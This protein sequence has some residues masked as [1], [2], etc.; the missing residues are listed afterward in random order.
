M[1]SL[2]VSFC[3][4]VNRIDQRKPSYQQKGQTKE[5]HNEVIRMVFLIDTLPVYN[6]VKLTFS[7]DR[8]NEDDVLCWVR[9]KF[10]GR[11]LVELLKSSWSGNGINHYQEIFLYQISMNQLDIIAKT[12]VWNI[13]VTSLTQQIS[14]R[15]SILS[16]GIKT[17]KIYLRLQNL[18]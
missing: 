14:L 9:E 11:N 8:D 7:S 3:R 10:E 15:L 6:E 1:E 16:I 13:V 5:L 2:S 12:F 4:I 17:S 18:A